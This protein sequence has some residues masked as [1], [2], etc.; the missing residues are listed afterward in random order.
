[1]IL[2]TLIGTDAVAKHG[3]EVNDFYLGMYTLLA[4]LG[5]LG[6][7]SSAYVF[8]LKVVPRTASVLHERLLTTVMAAPLS[9]FTT[10]DTGIT[11]N[12]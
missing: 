10:T 7:I 4:G 8:L 12:R 3:N 2:I 9:F 11:T 5:L 1:M 6:L